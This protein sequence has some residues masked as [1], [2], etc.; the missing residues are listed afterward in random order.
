M[1]FIYTKTTAKGFE[2]AVKSVEEEIAKVGMRVL[3][4]HDVQKTLGEKG[5][6]RDS[7]RIIEFCNA[8]Y[9]N[10]FLNIDIR[11]GLCLPCKIN[12]YI[13]DSQTFISGM[14]P[15]ILSQ[16]FPELDLGNKPQEIDQKIQDIINNAQ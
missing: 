2:D 11:I 12:V 14:R 15:I 3:H 8:Q 7:F 10:D 4:I 1:D 16:F 13:K 9:A 5:F 6:K